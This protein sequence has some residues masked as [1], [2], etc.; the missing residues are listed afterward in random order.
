MAALMELT[1]VGVQHASQLTYYK[2]LTYELADVDLRMLWNPRCELYPV[3]QTT[4][5]TSRSRYSKD[6][7]TGLAI[8]NVKIKPG[9][10][11]SDNDAINIASL[12]GRQRQTKPQQL[13][14]SISTRDIGAVASYQSSYPQCS[15]WEQSLAINEVQQTDLDDDIFSTAVDPDVSSASFTHDTPVER[16]STTAIVADF[17]AVLGPMPTVSLQ[18]RLNLTQHATRFSP[19]ATESISS[20]SR[21]E[22][23]PVSESSLRNK[24]VPTLSWTSQNARFPPKSIRN[25]NVVVT[26]T[27]HSSEAS[28]GWTRPV[29]TIILVTFIFFS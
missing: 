26:A 16:E 11:S 9:L 28:K 20:N 21:R 6:E 17:E 23:L 4:Q 8:D 2:T 12:L 24:A 10:S 3:L 27:P 1:S 13:T 18:D 7:I 5:S 29:F 14:T 19:P 22:H 15:L 25:G